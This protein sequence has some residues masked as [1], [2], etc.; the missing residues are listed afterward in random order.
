MSNI[1]TQQ[2]I[3]C[4]QG[5]INKSQRQTLLGQAP[6]TLWLTGLRAVGWGEARTPTLMA[7]LNYR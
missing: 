2:N 5:Q 7:F 3:V 4:H 6:L 1:N